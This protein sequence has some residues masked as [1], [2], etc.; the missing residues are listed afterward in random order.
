MQALDLAL[1]HALNA[2]AATAPAVVAA[3]LWVSQKMPFVILG[4]LLALTLAGPAA[5]RRPLL[6]AL[7][8]VALAWVNVQLLRQGLHVPRPGEL[9]IG[10]QWVEHGVRTGFPS[11]HTAAA[12]ALAAGIALGRLQRGLAWAA[13]SAALAMGWSRICLGAHFPTDVVGGAAVGVISA[14]CVRWMATAI[15]AALPQKS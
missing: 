10:T 7:A 6:R 13:W 4:A 12:F 3:A 2:D 14:C 8:A 9:G 15:P 1:F 5:Q 11:M